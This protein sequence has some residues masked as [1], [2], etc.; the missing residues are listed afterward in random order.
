MTGARRRGGRAERRAQRGEHAVVEPVLA[1]EVGLDDLQ[2]PARLRALDHA[3]VV[4]RGHGHDL[5]GA[6]HVAD[7][8]E[9]DRVGDRAGGDD[10]AVALHQARDRGDRADAARV[11]Q[12]DVGAREVVG[13]QLVLARLGDELVEG[14]LEVLEAQAA[15]VADDRHHQGAAAVLLLH[16]HGDAE[17]H[18][19]VVDARRLAVDRVEVMGHDRHVLLGGQ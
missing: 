17:V 9:A 3:V 12:L 7:V 5:L 11:G 2:E 8:P 16:V 19:A 15:R 18:G 1:L 13:G 10:R 6:D 14:G 4:R